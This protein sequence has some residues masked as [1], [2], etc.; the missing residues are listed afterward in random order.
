VADLTDQRPNVFYELGVRHTFQ[1]RTLLIAQT[2]SDIPTDL[3]GYACV[4][5]DWTSDTGHAEFRERVKEI[6]QS[7]DDHPERSDSPV[8]EFLQDRS[9]SVYQF[10]KEE[11]LLKLQALWSEIDRIADYIDSMTELSPGEDS[12]PGMNQPCPALDHLI[13]TQ[14]L[15]APDF[16]SYA[17][18]L[19]GMIAMVG[20][21][22]VAT[23][24]AQHVLRALYTFRESVERVWA[25]YDSGD[26]ILDLSLEDF[27]EHDH[28][29]GT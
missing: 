14:Y 13:A 18:K 23:G 22:E 8:S 21:Q 28:D 1:N 25:A 4:E 12:I 19:R 3:N 11:N 15:Y 24:I 27:R 20:D 10:R 5:Y 29:E 7:L 17:S 26:S 16:N 9:I 6:L 2:L